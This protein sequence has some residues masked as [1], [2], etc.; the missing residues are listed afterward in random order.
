MTSKQQPAE[1]RSLLLPLCAVV[2]CVFLWPAMVTFDAGDW[3]SPHQ[4]PHNTP[5]ANACGTVGA[6][7]AYYLQYYL[8][9]GTYPLLLFATL[10]SVLRLLRGRIGGF[11]ERALGLAL[12]V[13]CTSISAHLISAQG[14]SALPVGH[15]GLIGFAL[16]ELMTE[17]LSRLGTLIVLASSFF[18]GLMFATEGWVLKLPWMLKRVGQVSGSAAATARDAL[19]SA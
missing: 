4:Y 19:A 12:V 15:G 6:W 18:V 1:P 5:A 8:G 3:P 14:A 2:L 17:N 7:L 11:L 16:G 10:A 9:D 13:A